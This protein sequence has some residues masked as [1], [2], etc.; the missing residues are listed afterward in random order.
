[1]KKGFCAF[2]CRVVLLFS[3]SITFL[4]GISKSGIN[5][6]V[7]RSD[8]LVAYFDHFSYKRNNDFYKNDPLSRND[9]FYHPILSG[10]FSDPSICNN[11]K[12]YFLVTSIFSYFSGVSLFHCSDMVNWKQFNL[13]LIKIK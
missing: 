1:M 7:F 4:T 13:M 2:I 10:C 9:C 8:S 3:L 11:G 12:D 6:F 5:C